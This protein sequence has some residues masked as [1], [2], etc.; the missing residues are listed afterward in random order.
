MRVAWPLVKRR[1]MAAAFALVVAMFAPAF[2]GQS[3]IDLDLAPGLP[4]RADTGK[5]AI[6]PPS[7]TALEQNERGK[8]LPQLPCGTR[9]LGTVRRNGAVELQVPA[10]DW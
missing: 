7:V 8:C 10:L 2:A 5:P 9:L 1:L 3:A 6:V 4:P